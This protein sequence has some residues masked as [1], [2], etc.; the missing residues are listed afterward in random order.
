MSNFNVI[1]QSL[2]DTGLFCCWV[3]ETRNGRKT[4]VPYDPLTGQRAQTNN[5]N[6]F[7]DFVTALNEASHYS[8][9]GF[10]ITNGLFVIDCDNCKNPDGSLTQPTAEIVS[11]FKD[12][13]MEWSPS[14]K[15]LHIIAKADGFSFNKNTYW[16]N[17]R[18]L[19]IEAY[20]SGVTNRFMTLT[21]NVFHEGDIL[22][23]STEL[24]LFLDK[25]MRRN[26]S[27][28]VPIPAPGQST[29]TDGEITAKAASARN[30]R[31]FR[32]LWSGDTAGYASPSEADFAL[33]GILAFWCGRDIDQMDRLFRQSGLYR[34]KWNRK[35]GGSTYGRI[36]LEKA[37]A[38]T[39][40][41]YH[42][43]KKAASTSKRP[44]GHGGVS[45]WDLRPE[46]NPRYP[47]ADIGSGRLFADYYKAIARYVRIRKMWHVF[48]GQIWE[49]DI[50]ALSIMKLAKHLAD[51][52][53]SY[54]TQI[55]DERKR[56]AY[57]NYCKKWQK[58]AF[59]ET[60]IKEAQSEYP[61]KLEEFD[62]DLYAYNFPSKT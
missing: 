6:T 32:Q 49:P 62:A 40:N 51:D 58:L 13:Y 55:P 18:K 37:A 31:L 17:N 36:T 11:I 38:E 12:C 46:D 20:I 54:A 26:T 35:Q 60:V 23:K 47:W 56:E 53:I 25:Y 5:P 7:T 16:M 30:G 48:N 61:I 24:Q 39:K 29:L 57:I 44:L 33:A 50:G 45:L 59:R 10:L 52:I 19:G 3:S 34:E 9:L 42:S 14:G 8:G 15:G 1:P 22:E 4:K 27:I 21:G 28:L 2:R 43:S 41:V